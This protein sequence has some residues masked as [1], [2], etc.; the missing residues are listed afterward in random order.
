MNFT[1][2]LRSEVEHTLQAIRQPELKLQP[3]HNTHFHSLDETRK[4]LPIREHTLPDSQ[5]WVRFD[6]F[7]DLIARSQGL[8]PSEVHTINLP[9]ASLTMVEQYGRSGILLQSLSSSA[10]EDLEETFPTRTSEGKPVKELFASSLTQFFA[11]ISTCSLK[12][13]FYQPRNTNSS[14]ANLGCGAVTEMRQLRQRIATSARAVEGIRALRAAGL[15]VNLFLLSWKNDIKPQNEYRVFCAPDG[16]AITAVSQYR[17]FDPWVHYQAGL[18][19]KTKMEAEARSVLAGVR[20]IHR[21]LMAHPE[22][23]RARLDNNGFVFDVVERRDGGVALLE[24]NSFGATS[25]CGSCLYHWI[26]DAQQLYAAGGDE[27]E[28]EFRVLAT[29]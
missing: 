17:W 3:R 22:M 15:L 25:G 20:S 16:G 10:L 28:V 27:R 6:P 7:V 1:L 4:V 14:N 9:P 11:R 2:V 12:D 24:L 19:G 8:D 21:E 13:S 26:R 29:G 5:P 18:D 23:S